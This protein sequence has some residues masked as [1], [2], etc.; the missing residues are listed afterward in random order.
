MLA[1][2][3]WPLRTGRATKGRHSSEEN[4]MRQENAG[5]E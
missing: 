2:E 4:G 1:L 5:Q 3:V